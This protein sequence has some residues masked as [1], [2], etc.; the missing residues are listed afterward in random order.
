MPKFSYHTACWN[1]TA[2]FQLQ[3]INEKQV[4]KKCYDIHHEQQWSTGSCSYE[5][6]LAKK[7]TMN[8][9]QW[10]PS[11][12]IRKTA[13]VHL[14]FPTADSSAS[15]LFSSFMLKHLEVR[16][17][18]QRREL[19]LQILLTCRNKTRILQINI[20]CSDPLSFFLAYQCI[21][22]TPPKSTFKSQE[23]LR[24]YSSRWPITRWKK[25][26]LM[27][28]QRHNPREGTSKFSASGAA[29]TMGL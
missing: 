8:H 21:I 1:V 19:S 27:P 15:C 22:T 29:I 26:F 25:S 10:M 2:K 28:G 5:L 3:Q 4:I 24:I 13:L 7:V 12:I 14:D 17:W 9:L 11:C 23:E 18:L 6:L 20:L 16:H